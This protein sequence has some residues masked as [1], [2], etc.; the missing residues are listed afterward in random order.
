MG[1]IRELLYYII[2]NNSYNKPINIQNYNPTDSKISKNNQK[3]MLSGDD[4]FNL[5]RIFV[6]KT[7][8]DKKKSEISDKYD[9]IVNGVDKC[10]KVILLQTKLNFLILICFNYN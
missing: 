9:K 8:I 1:K 2:K 3:R 7:Y 6:D 4:G 5:I 10:V